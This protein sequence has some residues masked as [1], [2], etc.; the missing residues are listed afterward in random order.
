MTANGRIDLRSD[1]VTHPTAA[2]R[3][4]MAAAEVG[5]DA[6][7][8]DPT[9]RRLEETVAEMFGR[10][11]AMLTPSGVMATQ[12][13]LATVCPRGSELIC[14]D[15]AHVA[16][17]EIG[18][19]AII[20]NVQLRTVVGD[21]GRLDAAELAAGLRP[22]SYPHTRLGGISVEEST[23]RGG[24]A[25]Y[26]IPRL[27]ELRAVATGQG[28]A[29]HGDGARLFNA[30]VATGA[31]PQA[32]G[33]VFDVFSFCLSKGLGAPVGSVAVGDRD[34]IDEARDW[35]RRLG[36][37]MRQAGVLA[38]A[39]LYALEH[40]V[41]RLADDHANAARIAE[42]L[43][44]RVP[45]SVDPAT[46]ETNMVFVDTGR[47]NAVE[48]AAD[49]AKSG[50]LVGATGPVTLRLVTHLDADAA[51]CLRAAEELAD[52]LGSLP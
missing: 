42:L 33:E 18:S 48:L 30:I 44:Q 9:V 1:T 49:M 24:G 36:G 15:D 23:N 51:G 7:G 19:A 32:Y 14:A 35:R 43:A 4:A 34:V 17:Y 27:R 13:L 6:Y 8:E 45:G 41:D 3:A 11:A 16:A 38:A 26:G 52:R 20:A 47:S 25:I 50:I 40:H 31:T 10:E 2:M 28:V 46:V 22:T 37:A 5:D 12:T 29:L 39:G 21:R